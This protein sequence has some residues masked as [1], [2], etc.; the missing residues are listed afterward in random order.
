MRSARS[1]MEAQ[2]SQIGTFT[3]QHISV[4]VDPMLR[5]HG[6]SDPRRV[7]PAI[8]NA[9]ETVAATAERVFAPEV[10]Y[11][12][13][14]SRSCADGVLVLETGTTFHSAAFSQFLSG[15][16]E[17]IVFVLTLGSNFDKVAQNLTDSGHTLEALFLETAG[18]LGVEAATK[19]FAEHLRAVLRKQGCGLTRRFG[20]GYTYRSRA[21]DSEWPLEEQKQLFALFHEHAISVQ[22]LD[23][24]AMIPKM[25]RSGLYG[26]R[27]KAVGQ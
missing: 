11:R 15:S 25:S 7:K 2:L 8:R 16:D 17:V 9:A 27:R 21:D 22:L 1:A 24:C 13:V 19:S 4:R 14:S 12:R 26:V 10:Y 20:P 23:S 6:Y 3:P 5:I 18:W